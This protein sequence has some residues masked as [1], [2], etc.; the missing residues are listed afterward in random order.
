M[1]TIKHIAIITSAF[2]ATVA[3]C[4]AGY[5]VSSE[6]KLEQIIPTIIPS[7]DLPIKANEAFKEGE[8]LS[9]RLHYGVMDAG[10]ILMEVKPD[11]MEVAGRK[12]YHIVGNGYSKGTFDWF[13]KVRDRYETFIEL[14]LTRIIRL[15]TILTK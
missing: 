5:Y 6:E 1:K 7:K 8:I 4:S 10:V 2:T 15:I 12:V 3:L 11:V 13:F 9:Y 14:Q